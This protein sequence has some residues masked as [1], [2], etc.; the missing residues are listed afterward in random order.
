MDVVAR[1]YEIISGLLR[2]IFESERE[3]IS[4]AARVIADSLEHGNILHVF[5]A[6]HSAMAGEELFYRAG[7]LVPVYPLINSDINL[8]HGAFRSTAME[9]VIGYAEILLNDHGVKEGDVVIVV[10]TSGVNVFPVEAAL[11]A[12]ERGARVIAITSVK[13]SSTLKPRNPYGKHLY[14]VADIVI[15]NHVPRGDAVLEIPGLE[16]K[17]AP[18]ST[19]TNSFIVNSIVAEA[20]SIL[21]SKGVKPPI[22][23]SAHLEG[24]EEW[25]KKMAAKYKARIPL[26][27]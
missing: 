25:N 3:N 21:V 6:G 13:Y 10:S 22:W 27:R 12:R 5:G 15:D 20:V 8:C 11:K 9:K 23:I 24:A 1:Y 17:V 4:K 19:I 16:T 14:E 7:G 2:E 26:L 18:V